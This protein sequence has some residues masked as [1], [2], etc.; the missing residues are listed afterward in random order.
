MDWLIAGAVSWIFG[1]FGYFVFLTVMAFVFPNVMTV[2]IYGFFGPLIWSGAAGLLA[3]F[4]M[5]FGL[6][7]WSWSSLDAT[8]VITALPMWYW[9]HRIAQDVRTLRR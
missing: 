9:T 6:L 8:F 7:P 1:S 2:F 4:G 3:L 5:V